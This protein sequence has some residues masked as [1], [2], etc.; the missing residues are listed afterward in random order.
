MDWNKL[1]FGCYNRKE[2][3]GAI[4][5]CVWQRVRV[6]MIGESLEVKHQTLIDYLGEAPSRRQEIQVTNYVYALKRGGLWK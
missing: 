5:D 3:L 1:I 6:S 2:V 4:D